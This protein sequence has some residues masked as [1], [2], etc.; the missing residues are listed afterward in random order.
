MIAFDQVVERETAE[1]IGNH[2]FECMI[3]PG[4]ESDAL[5]ILSESKNRRILTLDPLGNLQMNQR[6]DKYRR[7]A[8]SNPGHS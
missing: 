7:L 1:S 6:F 4:Y 8:I 3:A 5:E 2:F